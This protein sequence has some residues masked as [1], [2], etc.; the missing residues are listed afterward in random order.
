VRRATTEAKRRA[1]AEKLLDKLRS[2]WPS[3][4]VRP[5][6]VRALP[7]L[8]INGLLNA[9]GGQPPSTGRE[10]RNAKNIGTSMA[11]LLAAA[12]G[13]PDDVGPHQ[14]ACRICGRRMGGGGKE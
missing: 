4:K 3:L 14:C 2:E 13:L 12:L 5:T 1:H 10:L 9:I 8:A 11:A 7:T 6:L